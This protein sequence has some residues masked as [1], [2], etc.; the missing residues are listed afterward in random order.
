MN[1]YAMSEKA[2]LHC[3]MCGF[4][5]TADERADEHLRL[6]HPAQHAIATSALERGY[7]EHTM[8]KY[9][10]ND[11][12]RENRETIAKDRLRDDA[13]WIE[14]GLNYWQGSPIAAADVP[15]FQ[16]IVAKLRAIADGTFTPYVNVRDPVN[17]DEITRLRKIA[18]LA[19]ELISLPAYRAL[20]RLLDR[21]HGTQ[22]P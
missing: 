5:Y 19:E 7:D 21:V 6:R 2:R 9:M 13:D 1:D 16:R 20:A 17:D 18:E 8:P 11:I 3:G 12:E 14:S 4:V 15:Q 10:R 22:K